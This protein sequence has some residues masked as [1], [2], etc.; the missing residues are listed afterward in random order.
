MREAHRAEAVIAM[1][2]AV[3]AHLGVTFAVV[4]IA[5]VAVLV[6]VV[7]R[8][9]AV[10]MV[11][12]VLAGVVMM[13][14]GAAVRLVMPIAVPVAVFALVVVAILHV[15]MHNV[16]PA[17]VFQVDQH[18][19]R[20]DFNP[21]LAGGNRLEA[22]MDAITRVAV[23]EF[24][25]SVHKR[26]LDG[27][28]LVD[29]NLV[30][31]SDDAPLAAIQVAQR[32]NQ[33]LVA[34]KSLAPALSVRQMT[35]VAASVPSVHSVHICIV[36]LAV[37]LTMVAMVALARIGRI[38]ARIAVA[39][40]RSVVGFAVACAL[41]VRMVA[42]SALS[43]SVMDGLAPIA[44]A[45]NLFVRMVIS[46]TMVMSIGMRVVY[47]VPV[48]HVVDGGRQLDLRVAGSGRRGLCAKRG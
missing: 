33:G 6:F 16:F 36:V 13:Q 42:K 14:I 18:K 47:M 11:M 7:V 20:T 44:L 3:V 30:V 37:S 22:I 35:N 32:T 29:L 15:N 40:V 8:V 41:A 25:P 39:Q 21:E 46:M 19:V 24:V 27:P 9:L 2:G 5:I 28:I 31:G 43:V 4:P 45:P 34:W 26:R 17:V 12:A 38:M 1:L 10:T 48:V 23:E